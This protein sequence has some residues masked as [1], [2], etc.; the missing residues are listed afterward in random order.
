MQL[1]LGSLKQKFMCS[2]YNFSRSGMFRCTSLE[3][4]PIHD[5]EKETNKQGVMG[6][7]SG[8]CIRLHLS[9]VDS[10]LNTYSFSSLR[11]SHWQ[12]IGLRSSWL[13]SERHSHLFNSLVILNNT[14]AP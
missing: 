14:F 4:S 13:G 10:R 11:R 9:L 2:Q 3:A 5:Q 8:V 1:H 12:K 6:L 7:Q